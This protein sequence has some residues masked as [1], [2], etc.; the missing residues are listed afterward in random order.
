ML[1]HKII[2]KTFIQF[3]NHFYSF[4]QP[5]NCSR[6]S[7]SKQAAYSSCDIDTWTLQFLQWYNFYVNNF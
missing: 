4:V 1:T 5:A 3:S 6:Q 2:F 7:I